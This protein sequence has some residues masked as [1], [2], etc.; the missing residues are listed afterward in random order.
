MKKI[1]F[2]FAVLF[3]LQLS[4]AE[5]YAL[6]IAV[7][8]YPAK[9]GWSTISSVNDVPLIKG[10]LLLQGFKEA[11]IMTVIDA[12][13][14]KKGIEEAVGSLEK[15]IKKGDI[16]VVHYS[17]HGQQIFDDNADEVDG[18]DEALV[19]YDAYV[20]YTHNYKGENHL[21]DDELAN[22]IANFRNKL[23]K[24]GQLLITLDSCHSGSATRGQKTRGGQGA[25]VPPDW[26]K[27]AGDKKGSGLFE[28]TKINKDDAAPFI[29]ISGASADE[30]NYEYNGVGSLSFAFSKAM[31]ELGSDFTY[32]QLFSTITAS[33][34]G[35]APKQKPTIE[36]DIDYKLFKGDY[37][38]QQPYYE[39]TKVVRNNDIVNINAGEVNR[40]FKETTVFILPSGTSKVDESKILA[41]GKVTLSKFNEAII[42]LDKPLKDT[43]AKNYWVFIDQPAY[44]DIAVKVYFDSSVKDVK[45]KTDVTDFLTK[46]NL[47]EVVS[48]VNDSDVIIDFEK[49]NYKISYTKGDD[50]FAGTTASRG[51]A[52]AEIK[53]KIF[54]Y[55]QGTYLKGLTVKN[56]NY[57][58]EF[59]LLPIAFD[60]ATETF[61]DLLPETDNTNETGVFK[62]KA[63]QDFV[64]LQVTNKSKKTI[65]ISIVEINTAGEINPFFPSSDC[66]LNDNERRLAPGQTMVFKDCVY[67]FGPPYERLVLKGFASDKPLNFQS[68]V[69]TRGER[70]A[71]QN[72]LESFL[73]DSYNQTRS[74]KGSAV[75][76]KMDGFSTEFVYEIVKE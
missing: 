71:N 61:G 48:A 26:K 1:T 11:N 66:S 40:I 33:M 64:V 59:K 39:V 15:K 41:K 70:S 60:H 49:E 31:N 10:A 43:N 72:P 22:M 3:C 69:S 55:A 17:G 25:L 73:Q 21:R 45:A 38:K 56:E 2:L 18:L 6:I 37:I 29:M 9:G 36:G 53:A 74:S 57:E 8:D 50:S 7:G 62:V 20:K 14:T 47:G 34:N 51:D 13:A 19:P 5:K 27:S 52:L 32:R 4:A 75:S 54:N 12:Q 67:S 76:G 68:T 16:V 63:E 58:F 28:R 46:N 42:T 44:G 35:I 24:D 30:L 23:G 65:Y